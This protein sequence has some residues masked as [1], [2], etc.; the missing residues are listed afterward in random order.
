MPLPG[1]DAA[2]RN[3]CRMALAHLRAAGLPWDTDLPCAAACTDRERALLERQLA[4][5]VSCVPTSSMG[6]LFDA[7]SS[8][9][10]VRHRC[11]HEAQAALELEARALPAVADCGRPYAF[12]LRAG[13]RGEDGPRVLDPAPVLRAVVHD[14]RAGTP[15]EVVAARFH[16][17]VAGAVVAACEA[18]GRLTGVGTV[19][20]SGGVFANAVLEEACTRELGRRGFTVVRH[21]AVPC[22]DGGLALGQLL[23]AARTREGEGGAHV[24]GSARQ[25]R[26]H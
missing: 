21:R 13:P 12:G 10:G 24:P 5:G 7:V 8:L 14:L 4:R 19:A 26:R 9:A 2:V 25:G 1:G 16:H 11:D 17:A 3:P 18:A 6:R 15:T 20:L 22:G 23:V